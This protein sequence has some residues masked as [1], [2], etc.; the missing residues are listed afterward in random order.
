MILRKIAAVILILVGIAG[1]VLP[2]IPG[3]LLI[4]LGVLMFSGRRLRAVYRKLRAV[5]S[6][7]A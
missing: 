6:R 7:R 2:V 4:F 3:G 1:L 5:L